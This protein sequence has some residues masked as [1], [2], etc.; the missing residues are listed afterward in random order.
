MCKKIKRFC[1]YV[2]NISARLG[3]F[4]HFAS[5]LSRN[6][7][8]VEE[9]LSQMSQTASSVYP[10]SNSGFL[11]WL[12]TLF[13]SLL[14]N[15]NWI[16]SSSGNKSHTDFCG[17]VRSQVQLDVAHHLHEALSAL[18]G[19]D[20]EVWLAAVDHLGAWRWGWRL[21]Q[22]NFPQTVAIWNCEES[23]W[24]PGTGVPISCKKETREIHRKIKERSFQP[25]SKK[26]LKVFL[27]IVKW[28][29]NKETKSLKFVFL[30]KARESRHHTVWPR[31]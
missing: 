15:S 5:F 24:G 25:D 8:N 11:F 14:I 1:K 29:E 7:N 2:I 18:G 22:N 20:S 12:A 4:N 6:T 27:S 19:D 26:T 21:G 3:W 16:N 30:S 10:K 17:L 23:W 9:H 28:L 13:C 31:K